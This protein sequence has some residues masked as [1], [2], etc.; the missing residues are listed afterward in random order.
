MIVFV[1]SYT[2]VFERDQQTGEYIGYVPGWPGAHSQ[3][4]SIE[5]L[6]VHLTEVIAMLLEDGEPKIEST[7]IGTEQ[8]KVA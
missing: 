2:A 8:L 4:P 1:K 7:F 3:A 6:R 5:E